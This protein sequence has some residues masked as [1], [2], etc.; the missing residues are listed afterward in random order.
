M[1]QD[2]KWIKRQKESEGDKQVYEHQLS[3]ALSTPR[4]E[5]VPYDIN[6]QK[7]DGLIAIPFR[8]GP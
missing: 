4:L 6:K 2:Y 1:A 8:N 7:D 5:G 3:S